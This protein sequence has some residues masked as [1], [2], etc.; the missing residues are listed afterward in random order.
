LL[1]GEEEEKLDEIRTRDE[2]WKLEY[3]VRVGNIIGLGIYQISSENSCAYIFA[4]YI[5]TWHE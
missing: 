3:F 5:R 4:L 1:T 2:I